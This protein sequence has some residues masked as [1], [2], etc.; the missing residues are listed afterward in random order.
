MSFAP[1]PGMHVGQINIARLRAPQGDPQVQGF[2]DGVA[3]MNAL[4]ER[5]AGFVWR[6]RDESADPYWPQMIAEDPL[7]TVT[8][9][10][11]TSVEAVRAFAHK[12]VHRRFFDRRAEW[13][14]PLG[15]PHLAMW[16]V[17]PGT[18]PGL[19][20]GFARLDRIAAEGEGPEAFGWAGLR[21]AAD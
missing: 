18:R 5:S 2:F 15:R 20:E 9:S 10:V 12:T 14:V 11:W 1:P 17:A 13:F 6:L 3:R 19:A 7:L 16:P 4:A 8:V 21:E